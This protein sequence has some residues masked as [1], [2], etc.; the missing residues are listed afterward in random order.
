MERENQLR[1]REL[2]FKKREDA[3]SNNK[4]DL[5]KSIKGFQ[6]KQSEFLSCLDQS[7]KSIRARVEHMVESVA[8]MKPKNAAA[9][10]SVQESDISVQILDQLDA[11]KVS[12]IFNFMDK[13]ISARLQKQFMTMKK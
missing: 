13:E 9:L 8:A 2:E 1:S 10:L 6:K 11:K 4:K 3:L 7:E 5:E 12:K